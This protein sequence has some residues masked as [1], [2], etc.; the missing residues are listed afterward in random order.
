MTS[1]YDSFTHSVRDRILAKL[2]GY[3]GQEAQ[4]EMRFTLGDGWNMR[5]FP[6]VFG[7]HGLKPYRKLGSTEPP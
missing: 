6:A 5:L 1:E 7:P 2:R 3:E 4:I